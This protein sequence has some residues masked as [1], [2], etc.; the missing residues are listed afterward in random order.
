MAEDSQDQNVPITLETVRKLLDSKLISLGIPGA[1][2]GVAIDF[3]RKWEW[4]KA[5]LCILAAAGVWLFIKVGSKLSPRIDK[6]LDWILGNAERLALDLWAKITSDFEGKYYQRLKFDCREYEIRGINRGALQLENVFVPLKM[7]QTAAEL[8]K[9]D[10]IQPL[11]NPLQQQE[12]GNLLVQM[13]SNVS[14]KRLAILG[15][16]GCGKSTLLRHI[17][18]MYA[19][20]KQRRLH[21]QAPKLIPVLLQLR[22]IY[23][24][25]I[26]NPEIPL[27]EVIENA[28]KKLQASEPLQPR[29]GWFA[30]QLRQN[31]CL[32][33]LDGL[34]E[35]PDDSQRQDV[36]AWVDRQ[37]KTEYPNSC[38]ILTSR[39][40]GYKKAPLTANVYQLEVQPFTREQRDKFIQDW[41]LHRVKLEYNNK[42]DL[43][44]RDRAKKQANNLIEQIEASSSLKLMARNPL[45][46][47]MIA[48]THETH[49][50]LSNKRVDLYKDICRVLLEGRQRAKGLNTLLSAEQKQ[51]VLKSL[52][53]ELM[54]QNTQ[55]FTLDEFSSRDK[56]YKQAKSLI[57]EKL[58]RFPQQAITPEDFIK[59]DDLGVRE[60]MSEKQ[61]EGIYEF[62]HKTFQEYLAAVEI[63][64]LQPEQQENL[65]IAAF[66]DETKLAWWRETIRFYAAQ[67]DASQLI[68]N[69]LK[70]ANISVLTL[71]YQCSKEAQQISPEIKQQ[72][73][74]KLET[75]L[76]SDDLD[77]F[78]LAAEVKLADRMSQLNHDLVSLES[79]SEQESFA[80]DTSYITWTEYQLFLNETSSPSTL[81]NKRQAQQPVTNISFWD[82]N[83]FC[84]WLS[85]RS[86]QELGEPGI[87]YRPSLEKDEQNAHGKINIQIKLLRFQVPTRYAQLAYYLAAVMWKEAD[88]ETLKVMLEVAG[89]EKQGYLELE[90]IEQFPCEDLKIIDKLWVDY[91]NGYFGFSVQ[92]KIYLEEGGILEGNRT[93]SPFKKVLARFRWIYKSFGVRVKEDDEVFYKAFCRFGDRVGW[94]VEKKWLKP[95]VDVTSHT[96]VEAGHLPSVMTLVGKDS[97]TGLF[98][99]VIL[100]RR[101]L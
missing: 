57:K 89:R 12:I 37:I 63:T 100:S 30:K 83:R 64:D 59:K 86:R 43:G 72:L 41:S 21:P 36:S 52:A 78:T 66:N 96:S 92:K 22:D 61:Q 29:P 18:L 35:I 73:T 46:L 6:L 81:T 33:M 58:D 8:T 45:L 50:N 74:A 3:A 38:F 56:T 47:N 70:Y 82:A 17:T 88:E 71:A 23:Q 11:V 85:L 69:A 42:I 84:A 13:K 49:G 32:V 93:S 80:V 55:A 97:R 95:S 65:L 101:D 1:F 76:E 20:R 68:K 7:A 5:S 77:E 31:K 62:A 94:R 34:D 53:L 15:A 9:Q 25:I 26:N 98:C 54:Q 28:V 2:I 4:E 44:V 90:D 39:P 10:M 91:S 14:F 99:G 48:I 27:A 16:P 24:E 19:R 75:G 60:L 87:C 67:T 40:E 51:V 79:N